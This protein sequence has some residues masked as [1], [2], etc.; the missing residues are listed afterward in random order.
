MQQYEISGRSSD[1]KEESRSKRGEGEA[2]LFL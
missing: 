1:K 2:A